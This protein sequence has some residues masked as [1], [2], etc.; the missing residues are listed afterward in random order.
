MMKE[1]ELLLRIMD[2]G[3]EKKAWHGTNLR[4]A[5]RGIDT[6]RGRMAAGTGAA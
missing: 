6:R 3:F 1:L 2:E 4:G 5:I